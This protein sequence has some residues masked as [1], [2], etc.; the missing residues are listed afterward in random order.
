MRKERFLLRTIGIEERDLRKILKG[1]KAE[2]ESLV[3]GVDLYFQNRKDR[4][5]AKRLLK[6]FV[7]S[8]RDPLEVLVGKLLKKRGFTLA[9]AESCTGGMLGSLITSVPGSS[10]YFLGGV[11]SYDNKT[12][13]K[14]IKVRRRSLVR[15]GAVSLEVANE[16]ASGVRKLFGADVG[17][18]ITGIAGPKG[19]TK[20]KP[21]GLIYI[22]LAAKHFDY[23]G[24]F[25]FS[26]SR[27]QIRLKACYHTMNILR[28]FLSGGII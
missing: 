10:H 12:K 18:G 17:I 27:Y 2:R 28:N 24:R 3:F 20:K 21:V 22:A 9:I 11:V 26:G 25:H 4:Q 8:T 15:F 6:P 5:Q 1:F 19:G 16:M 23:V 14:I 7:Y 13:E